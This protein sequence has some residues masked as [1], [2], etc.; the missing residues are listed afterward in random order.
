MNQIIK[1]LLDL[2]EHKNIQVVRPQ[3][4]VLDF[5]PN[6]KIDWS[7]NIYVNMPYNTESLH[8]VYS[9]PLF[10]H[11]TFVTT[12]ITRLTFFMHNHYIRTFFS[13]EQQHMMLS[14]S[15]LKIKI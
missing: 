4:I 1:D 13:K 9:L 10:N 3:E 5:A 11:A 12:E 6:S 14:G 7:L 15:K 2:L 8:H